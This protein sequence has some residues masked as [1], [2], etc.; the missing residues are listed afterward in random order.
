M[1]GAAGSSLLLALVMAGGAVGAGLRHLVGSALLRQLGS[2][3][4][5]WGTLA[6]N[7]A[8]AMAAG[9]LLVWLEGRANAAVWRAL[10]VVGLL[11]GLTTFSSLM[12]ELLVLGRDGRQAIAVGYLLVSLSGGMALVWAGARLAGWIRG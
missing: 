9:F 11:G 12:V 6:V 10:L 8:G 3:H 1:S 7:L 5:P 2:G 4:W